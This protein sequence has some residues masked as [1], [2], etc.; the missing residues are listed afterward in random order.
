MDEIREKLDDLEDR[1]YRFTHQQRCF[2][3]A[4]T[5]GR[6]GFIIPAPIKTVTEVLALLEGEDLER[7]KDVRIVE[8]FASI[9]S[10]IDAL[11]KQFKHILIGCLETN[12]KIKTSQAAK[13]LVQCLK[14]W[15]TMMDPDFDFSELRAKYPHS[16]VERLS[17]VEAREL[18]AGVVSFLPI[19]LDNVRIAFIYLQRVFKQTTAQIPFGFS[20]QWSSRSSATSLSRALASTRPNSAFINTIRDENNN[21]ECQIEGKSRPQ[22]AHSSLKLDI[23]KTAS[24]ATRSNS[25]ATND[26]ARLDTPAVRSPSAASALSRRSSGHPKSRVSSS[27]NNRP[28]TSSSADWID[29]ENVDEGLTHGDVE[30]NPRYSKSSRN[31]ATRR[32]APLSRTPLSTIRQRLKANPREVSAIQEK[33]RQMRSQSA[34]STPG[35]IQAL[36]GSSQNGKSSEN[37]YKQGC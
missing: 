1:Y 36:D 16:V 8:A 17:S 35:R 7:S 13:K 25:L 6:R 23:P 10:D 3:D 21:E 31:S 4:L 2:A 15:R 37:G 33:L 28:K 11:R 27:H 29:I 26:L 14:K 30:V 12:E 34:T 24:N 20:D 5:A 18:Y 22:T 9:F 19:A 32:S